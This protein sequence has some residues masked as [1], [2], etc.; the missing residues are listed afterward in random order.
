VEGTWQ[1]EMDEWMEMVKSYDTGI[2]SIV[3]EK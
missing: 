1:A 2:R 3:T